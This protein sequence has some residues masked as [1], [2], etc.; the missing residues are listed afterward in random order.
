LAVLVMKKFQKVHK[1]PSAIWSKE[2]IVI[3][4]CA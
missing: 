2:L 4:P 3:T 1:I